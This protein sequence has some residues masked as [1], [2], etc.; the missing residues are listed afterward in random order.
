[1]PSSTYDD[2]T[3]PFDLLVSTGRGLEGRCISAIKGILSTTHPDCRAS[4]TC[5]SGLVKAWVGPTRRDAVREV[6]RV[7]DEEPWHNEV[8]KRVVPI[9]RVVALNQADILSAVEDLQPDFHPREEES[10]RVTVRKRGAS[11]DRMVLIVALAELFQN[12]VDLV[13]PDFEVR[14][15]MVRHVSG[16][17]LIRR[18]ESFPDI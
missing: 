6:V 3:C 15:E 18:G 7:L 8:I 14:V 9:D 4:R 1:M 12:K 5:F 2:I 10:F 11:I 16:V 13:N 17:S